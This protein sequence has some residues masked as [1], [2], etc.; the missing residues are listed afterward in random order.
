MGSF[1]KTFHMKVMNGFV[2]KCATKLIKK[3]FLLSGGKEIV[4]VK[5]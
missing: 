3:A 5:T 2:Q 1:G 4:L